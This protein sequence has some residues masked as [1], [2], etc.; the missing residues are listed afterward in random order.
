MNAWEAFQQSAA[1]DQ[2]FNLP[3]C[4]TLN[5]PWI[6]FAYALK[7]SKENGALC[8]G[9]LIAVQIMAIR[10]AEKC[11]IKHGLFNRW[12][13]CSGGVFSYDEA[14]GMAYISPELARELCLYLYE[15]DGIYCNKPDEMNA[16]NEEKFNLYR[17]IFL[18]PYLRAR[19]GLRVGLLSKLKFALHVVISTFKF[20]PNDEEGMSKIWLMHE[21][22][23]RFILC[24][25]A[26]Y[27]WFKKLSGL[28]PENAFIVQLKEVKEFRLFAPE[29]W[30]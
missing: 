3:L 18:E 8:A 20:N 21:E 26:F 1:W 11:R 7:I 13:D 12:P 2:R 15:Q 30:K 4:P 29:H 28:S 16:L 23:D 10:H 9:A 17:F 6:Y 24:R 14:L 19:A 25:I 22:M 27:F 5:N